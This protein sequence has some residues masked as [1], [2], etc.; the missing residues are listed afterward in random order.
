[1]DNKVCV[2]LATYNGEQYL[3]QM[4]D[5][6]KNQSYQDFVCYIHDDGSTDSTHKIIKEYCQNYEDKFIDIVSQSTG[7]A[8]NN[9]LYMLSEFGTQFLYIMFCDQ[10]DVWMSDK[11]EKSLNKI[12]EVENGNYNKPALVYSDMTVV[13]EKLNTIASS[14][15]KYNALDIDNI[16]L[17]RAV[18]KGYAAGCSMILNNTLAK[19]SSI[20]NKNDIIMHDW[21]VLLIA[22]AVGSI[23]YINEPLA[24]YRQHGT[25]TLG[26]KHIT[27]GSRICEILRRVVT[28]EQFKI[29]RRGLYIRLNQLARCAEVPL[30]K[31]EYSELVLGAAKFKDKKKINRCK[32]VFKNRL[33]QNKW[34]CIW[35]CICA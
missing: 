18:M 30:V 8:M 35:T 11:I 33:Y 7:G 27:V 19:I 28:L 21:W 23:G 24:L 13:D 20:K 34:S 10:D 2:L 9:F 26:A 3:K 32:F 14:F 17:D 16:T 15:I 4:L 31:E 6:I 5:S 12:I 22:S 25:N 29:T 1:M